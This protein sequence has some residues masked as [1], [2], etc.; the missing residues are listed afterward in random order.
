MSAPSAKWQ[1]Q[2]TA[3]FERSAERRDRHRALLYF[4]GFLVLGT[5]VVVLAI[6]GT[7]LAVHVIFPRGHPDSDFVVEPA[8]AAAVLLTTYIMAR[9]TKQPFLSFGL[10]GSHRL[11]NFVI[12]LVAGIALLAFLLLL[13]LALDGLT[14][15]A[16]F[17]SGRALLKWGAL[18]GILFLIVAINE[19]FIFRGFG[20][21]MLSRAISFWPAC[22]VLATLFGAAHLHNIG[23]D[24][25]GAVSAGL[26]AVSAAMSFR[27]TGSLWY[28]VGV[29]T[30]IGY[31]ESFIFGVPNS[32]S[33][34]NE[35]LLRPNFHGPA[36]LTG[37]NV[38]PEGSV[39]VVIPLVLIVVVA[40]MLRERNGMTVNA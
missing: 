24:A 20:L 35:R 9:T 11:R 7:A 30:G 39:L 22:I 36:W 25:A 27:W 16:A 6:S 12:G 3:L 23:E 37:G 19:E 38:G 5:V 26:Y 29:H 32:G 8:S 34:L 18:Y 10:G 13:T 31:A 15:S 17:E 4:V 2:S 33:T 28:A 14:L 40:W 21:V 1:P